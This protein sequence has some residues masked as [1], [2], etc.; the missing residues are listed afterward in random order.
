[1]QASLE[2]L[3]QAAIAGASYCGWTVEAPEDFTEPRVGSP[4]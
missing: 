3:A 1:V 4:V 2:P